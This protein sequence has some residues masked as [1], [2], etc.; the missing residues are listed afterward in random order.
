[1]IV[2]TGC[3]RFSRRSLLS[4]DSSEGL[5]VSERRGLWRIA[6]WL[7]ASDPNA[8]SSI[9]ESQSLGSDHEHE[10]RAR[11]FSDT[12]TTHAH[13]FIPIRLTPHASSLPPIQH[14]HGSSAATNTAFSPPRTPFTSL[15]QSDSRLVPQASRLFNSLARN[16]PNPLSCEEFFGE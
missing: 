2:R 14:D 5:K 10:P 7:R 1:V 16:P 12:I 15:S 3:P 9:T 13:V 11:H 8:V 6:V 4:A